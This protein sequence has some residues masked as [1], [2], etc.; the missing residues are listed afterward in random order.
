MSDLSGDLAAPDSS[1][2]DVISEDTELGV[3]ESMPISE[4]Q[5]QAPA[6]LSPQQQQGVLGGVY[7]SQGQKQG[8][9][10]QGFGSQQQGFGRQMQG[11][12][13]Q[14]L[15]RQNQRGQIQGYNGQMQRYGLRSYGSA[16]GQLQQAP[17][18]GFSQAQNAYCK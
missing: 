3:P 15:A 10:Q 8:Q 5:V 2:L 12:Q 6:V 13:Q 1:D 4:L 17:G 7:G 16:V 14:N 9:Q 18:Y 11:F